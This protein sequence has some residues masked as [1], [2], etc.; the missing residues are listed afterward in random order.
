MAEPSGLRRGPGGRGR[1]WLSAAGSHPS[2]SG[3]AQLSQAA[4]PEPMVQAERRG[5]PGS[6]VGSHG[7]LPAPSLRQGR[8]GA[9]ARPSRQREAPVS[10]RPQTSPNIGT[11]GHSARVQAR[12]HLPWSLPRSAEPPPF[13]P[14]PK[15]SS[16]D[17]GYDP[18]PP[19]SW[20]SQP[21]G[22]TPAKPGT[23]RPRL[24]QDFQGWSAA[25][26]DAGWV[27]LLP[28]RRASTHTPVGGCYHPLH[29][30]SC[31]WGKSQ[32]GEPRGHLHSCRLTPPA[33]PSHALPGCTPASPRS[34]PRSRCTGFCNRRAGW[35]WQ[36]RAWAALLRSP[37]F[38][39]DFLIRIL[40]AARAGR[41]QPARRW[42]IPAGNVYVPYVTHRRLG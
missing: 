11:A 33:P 9:A 7:T 10:K 3:G 35:G 31:L 29:G 36:L 4:V 19:A 18:P 6:P 28:N 27:R 39:P 21:H 23:S 5:L 41:G 25:P 1:R 16:D 2:G 37:A 26:E 34:R 22:D 42:A 14:V 8:V 30:H 13:L 38:P 12:S 40:N 32:P 20:G 17:R 15:H 24:E